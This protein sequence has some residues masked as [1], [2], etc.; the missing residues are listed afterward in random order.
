MLDLPLRPQMRSERCCQNG[1]ALRPVWVMWDQPLRGVG[2]LIGHAQEDTRR[3]RYFPS[4]RPGTSGRRRACRGELP[5]RCAEGEGDGVAFGRWK[6]LSLVVSHVD[7]HPRSAGV[8]GMVRHSRHQVEVQ[9]GEPLGFGELHEVR[10]H[11]A[12]ESLQSGAQAADEPTEFVGGLRRQ[13]RE[14]GDVPGR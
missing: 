2:R 12:G 14:R 4:D 7:K 6:P 3:P 5:K 10:L 1:V 9:V 11:A 8:L 13:I